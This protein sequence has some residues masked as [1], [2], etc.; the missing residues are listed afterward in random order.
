MDIAGKR[1]VVTGGGGFLGRHLVE[2]FSRESAHV[3]TPR[4]REYDLV[5]LD[6]ARRMFSDHRCDVAVHAAA[7]VGGIGYNRLY[8]ADIFVN[9]LLMTSNILQAAKEASVEKLVIIGSACAYPGEASGLL[10]EEDLL[11]GPLHPTVEVYGFSKRALYIGAKAFREQYGLNSIFLLLT[12]LYGP[13]DKMSPNESHVVAALVRKF[14]EAKRDGKQ[15]V[16]C[17]GT[18][19]PVR[20]FLYVADCADAIV[21]A[22]QLYDKPE[23]L[24]IGTGVGTSIRELADLLA[25]VTG[26]EGSIIWDTSKLDGAMGKVLDVTRMKA[27]LGWEASVSMRE[28]LARTIEWYTS[29]AEVAETA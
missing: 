8:P 17:W 27:E 10:T 21:R 5:N 14:T 6:A 24:N 19:K 2:R 11:S 25:D 3:S 15:E 22:T 13:W 1:V 16:V 23:P 9:N 28:G 7:D 18:G 12:N 26:Y 4:S 29:H 20:E